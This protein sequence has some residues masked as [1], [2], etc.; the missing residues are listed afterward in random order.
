MNVAINGFG[1]IGRNVFKIAFERANVDVVAIND[2][3]DPATLAHLLKYDS[4]FGVYD[5]SVKITDTGIVVDGKEIPVYA[6]RDPKS[7][8]WGK[9][10]VDIAVEST[11]Q[12]QL[13]SSTAMAKSPRSCLAVDLRPIVKEWLDRPTGLGA[14]RLK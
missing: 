14:G 4:N 1:R 11:V 7:L 5:K 3:T 13:Q 2:I 9:L 12:Q 8:P 10:G 6:E